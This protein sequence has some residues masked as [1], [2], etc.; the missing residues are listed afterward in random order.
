[1]SEAASAHGTKAW[2]LSWRLLVDAGVIVLTLGMIAVVAGVFIAPLFLPG[3]WLI[4]LSLLCVAAGGVL[5]VVSAGGSDATS[6]T[7]RPAG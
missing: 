6:P 5:N 7:G 3:T 1:M 4:A 2:R